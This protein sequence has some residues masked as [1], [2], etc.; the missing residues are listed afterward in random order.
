MLPANSTHTPHKKVTAS[1]HTRAV[2]D[3]G[4]K[5]SG[6]TYN[7]EKAPLE[8]NVFCIKS[9]T[10]NRRG[11]RHKHSEKFLC[12]CIDASSSLHWLL[13]PRNLYL[14]WRRISKQFESKSSNEASNY[15]FRAL[16]FSY[17]F[18]QLYF[19]CVCVCVSVAH[20]YIQ[21]PWRSVYQTKQWQWPNRMNERP[22][23]YCVSILLFQLALLEQIYIIVCGR[24]DFSRRF[25]FRRKIPFKLNRR[26]G[27]AIYNHRLAASLHIIFFLSTAHKMS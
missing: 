6:T 13:L 19:C 21:R 12:L 20:I 8:N 26:V 5:I 16:R 25:P 2:M 14:C 9:A 15:V 23:G 4:K 27:T 10:E 22:S 3:R 18:F 11:R 24:S 7:N 1:S 17:L